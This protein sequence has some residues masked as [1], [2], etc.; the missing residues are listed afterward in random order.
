[1]LP[2]VYQCFWLFGQKTIGGSLDENAWKSISRRRLISCGK[3][4]AEKKLR[5]KCHT[6]KIL[7]TKFQMAKLDSGEYLPDNS[8]T[9]AF[10]PGIFPSNFQKLFPPKENSTQK[11]LLFPEKFPSVCFERPVSQEGWCGGFSWTRPTHLASINTLNLLGA[12]LGA[13]GD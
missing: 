5:R 9:N 2:V 10:S 11:E 12:Q 3:V 4:N 6:A 13:Q 1:M 8:S 7:A